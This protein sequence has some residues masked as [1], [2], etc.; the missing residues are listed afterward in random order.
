MNM[1]ILILI[2]GGFAIPVKEHA[3]M[4][5]CLRSV[6]LKAATGDKGTYACLPTELVRQ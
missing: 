3:S 1:F 6:N 5:A 4:E 2:V